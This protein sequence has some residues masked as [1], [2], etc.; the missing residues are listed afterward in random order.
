MYDAQR[1]KGARRLAVLGPLVLAADLLLLLGG[2]IVL[3]IERLADLIRRFALDHVRDSLAA[4]IEE[5]LDIKV[6]GSLRIC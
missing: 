2:E 3:D 5:G 4:D 6:V 1:G